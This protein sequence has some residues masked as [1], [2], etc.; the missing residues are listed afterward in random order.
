MLK[1]IKSLEK[2]HQE[3]LSELILMKKM[4]WGSFCLIHVKC[5]K[6]YCKCA[7]GGELHPH[8]RMSWKENGKGMSRA[9]PK[10]ERPW[11]AEMTNNYKKFRELRRQ[12]NDVNEEI[13]TFLDAYEE[14]I[15]K[16]TRKGKLY[17]EI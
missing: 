15:V 8:W 7:T 10:E 6:K 11:I 3:I 5:G 13:K 12:L 14:D 4:V 1:K 9:V 17:L 2:K 16:K